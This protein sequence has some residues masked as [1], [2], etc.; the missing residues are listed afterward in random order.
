MLNPNL[1]H[2]MAQDRRADLRREAEEYRRAGLTAR[3][4][5]LSRITARIPRFPTHREPPE[6]SACGRAVDTRPNATTKD[7][8]S[9][10]RSAAEKP[11][12]ALPIQSALV[13]MLEASDADRYQLFNEYDAENFRQTGSYLGMTYSEQ[14][15]IVEIT[16][17]EDREDQLKQSLLVETKD[18]AGVVA[19]DDVFVMITEI[20]RAN[21]RPR[22]APP[23][24]ASAALRAAAC[25]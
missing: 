12:I 20:G 7:Q 13:S 8:P 16:S 22:P 21:S 17:L 10:G 2:Q 15:L 19:A 25:G 9:E 5:V 14:L 1:M 18:A 6:A 24:A 4:T 3:P 23:A 11:A